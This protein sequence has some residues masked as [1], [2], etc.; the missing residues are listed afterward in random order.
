MASSPEGLAGCWERAQLSPHRRESQGREPWARLHFY[1]LRRLL[2]EINIERGHPRP[3]S[4]TPW[5][6]AATAERAE[7]GAHG[8]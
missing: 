4:R 1:S 6:S 8:E 2:F 7:L 5:L 3:H